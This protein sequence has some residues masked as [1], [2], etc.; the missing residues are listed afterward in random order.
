M[1]FVKSTISDHVEIPT[2][3]CFDNIVDPSS[4]ATIISLIIPRN[5]EI[6]NAQPK[7]AQS[8]ITRMPPE[9]FSRGER[10]LHAG[11]GEASLMPMPLTGE[12]Q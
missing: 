9:S 4:F 6:A 2:D 10:F 7:S 1:I 11:F 12:T 8:P 3:V 5:H